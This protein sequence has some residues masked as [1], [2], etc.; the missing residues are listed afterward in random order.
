MK[1]SVAGKDRTDDLGKRLSKGVHS[2]PDDGLAN[3]ITKEAGLVLPHTGEEINAYADR[4]IGVMGGHT[5]IDVTTIRFARRPGL[6]G[7]A[8]W[9]LRRLMWKL[10]RFNFEW[11]TFK[12]NTINRQFAHQIELEHAARARQAEQLEKRVRTLESR[13]AGGKDTAK[14]GGR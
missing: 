9:L 5:N 4:Q 6:V 10:Q 8:G 12:Q 3:S 1:I 2:R 11:L 7:M 14:D 13:L